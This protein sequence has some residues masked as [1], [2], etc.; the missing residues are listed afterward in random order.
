[1]RKLNSNPAAEFDFAQLLTAAQ[2]RLGPGR[3]GRGA[4]APRASSTHAE[5]LPDCCVERCA[6]SDGPVSR[7][8]GRRA[9]KLRCRRSDGSREWPVGRVPV[10]RR[11]RGRGAVAARPTAAQRHACRRH[12]LGGCCPGAATA[13]FW[14]PYSVT[15]ECP[16]GR[17]RTGRRSSG[18][19]TREG[20]V[21]ESEERG[22]AAAD[23]V[24]DERT[25][26]GLAWTVTDC[27]R[28]SESGRCFSLTWHRSSASSVSKP[29]MT[30][31]KT[32]SGAGR[33][34]VASAAEKSAGAKVAG[35][36][37]GRGG[38]H[39][40]CRGAGAWRR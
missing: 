6:W 30:F 40:C 4:A 39:S 20:R 10:R 25:A 17:W 27:R 22:A 28:I 1:M 38:A 7:S 31:P 33:V 14:P 32:E 29:S 9:A 24:E 8:S 12:P 13:P 21:R 3:P 19:A 37:L 36:A 11:G 5:P 2:A 26:S 18:P 16:G 15:L 34:A 35:G 23:R